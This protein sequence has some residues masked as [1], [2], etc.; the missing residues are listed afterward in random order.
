MNFLQAKRKLKKLANGKYHS[1]IYEVCEHKDGEQVQTC[2]LYITGMG[3]Y[4]G[5]NWKDAFGL[6]NKE[7]TPSIP[8]VVD[9]IEEF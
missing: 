5:Q 8:V 4:A 9:P 6:L 7:I 1:V 2:T 3:F